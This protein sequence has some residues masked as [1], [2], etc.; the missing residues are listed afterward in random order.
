MGKERQGS[1]VGMGQTIQSN[2]LDSF[3]EVNGRHFKRVLAG[4]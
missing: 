2:A 1:E 3:S 4:E